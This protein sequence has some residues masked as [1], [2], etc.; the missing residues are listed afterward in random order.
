MSVAT[1]ATI[2]RSIEPMLTRC[3]SPITPSRISGIPNAWQTRLRPSA[4]YAPYSRKSSALVI[5]WDPLKRRAGFP[6]DPTERPS[7]AAT[8]SVSQRLADDV[9][10]VRRDLHMH[11]ELGFAEHRT[12]G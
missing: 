5:S 4:W 11:P 3:N 2:A 8:I 1:E 6:R 12:A 7:M 9:V 10:L